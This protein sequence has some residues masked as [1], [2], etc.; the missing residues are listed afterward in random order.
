M[1]IYDSLNQEQREAVFCTDGPLLL[2]AGAGSGKTRVLVHRIAYLI[3]EK[4]VKPWNIMA[5]T[6]TN[7]AAKE[8]RERVDDMIGYGASDCWVSTFHSS[9]VRILRRDIDK[10]G[11]SSNFSIYDTDDQKRLIKEVL[12]SLQYDTK[13]FSEKAMMNAISAAKEQYI[14]PADYMED[15][16]GDFR[17]E[18]IAKVYVNYQKQLETANALDFDDLLYKT[19]ELFEHHP[20]VLEYWQERF[21]Y[22]M[23]D[24][25]Q[26]T[27]G[28]Q[29]IFIKQLAS[30]YR[31]ICVVGDDDQS[32]YKFR[33][34]DV[35]NILEFEDFFPESTV[36]KLEQNYRSTKNI[37]NVANSVIRNNTARMDKTLYTDNDEGETTTFAQY[38]DNYKEAEA[39]ADEVSKIVASGANY[40]DFAVLN[41]TNAQS[42]VFE[43][44]FGVYNIPYKIVGGVSFYSR[45]EIRDIVAYLKLVNNLSDDQAMKRIINVPR[46]GIGQTTVEKI[47]EFAMEREIAFFD[48]AS[49]VEEI[50]TISKATAKKIAAFVEMIDGFTEIAD[51]GEIAELYDKVVE[52]TGY[53][54]NLVLE[55]TED[56]KDRINNLE[57]FKSKIVDYEN[58][59]AEPSLQGF[60]TDVAL[61]SEV[62]NLVSDDAVTVMT[63]HSAK[64]LEFP[65]VFLSGMEE[66]IFPGYM[67]INSGNDDDMEEERRLFYVGATR[68]EKR[69]YLS[70]SKRRMV[71]GQQQFNKVSRFIDEIDREYLNYSP[72]VDMSSFSSDYASD[73]FT[74]TKPVAMKPAYTL[75]SETKKYKDAV[76]DDS[77]FEIDYKVGDRVRHIKF[78]SGTVKEITPT[79][80]D[81]EVLVDYDLRGVRRS[82]ASFAKLKK[83]E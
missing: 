3:E 4:K 57:E 83:E 58:N 35:R 12:K 17:R 11:Y 59:E 53:L 81:Y 30:K 27:N 28:V 62:D 73:I 51:K 46:R 50:S 68:A 1:S 36:I 71:N 16:V 40:K 82:F 74:K 64:G 7:K 39:I 34:A 43:E 79:G 76:K 26:D 6:F 77:P 69:L 47:N 14:S 44:K 65:Y 24:E 66:G 61:I 9:C 20:D 52:E 21:R 31:N 41:R 25:Y 72:T 13:Q 60:L 33:G 37:L 70:A 10:L 22:I 56:A 8:M 38:Q 55:G 5:I 63:I 45:M 48:A 80:S 75:K 23:V 2:L 15:A 32:I 78:G 54:N 18:K 19:V 29:F 67:T 42:R 49:M